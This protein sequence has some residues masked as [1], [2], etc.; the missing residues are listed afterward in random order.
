MI[1]SPSVRPGPDRASRSLSLT[2]SHIMRH[3]T[4][5]LQLRINAV[6][7]HRNNVIELSRP[8]ATEEVATAGTFPFR[9]CRPAAALGRGRLALGRAHQVFSAVSGGPSSH[10]LSQMIASPHGHSRHVER[11][12]ACRH[13]SLST[14]T[15]PLSHSLVAEASRQRH[16]RPSPRPSRRCSRPFAF[17]SPSPWNMVHTLVPLLCVGVRCLVEEGIE[18]RPK[19]RV[20]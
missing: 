16:T 2:R 9:V 10:G 8:R 15:H 3:S 7:N 5:A 18:D 4:S 6:Q 11:E 1:P 17:C 14:S 19:R 20:L 12:A 13:R